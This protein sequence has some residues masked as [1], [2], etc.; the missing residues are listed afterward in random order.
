MQLT[1]VINIKRK[2]ILNRLWRLTVNKVKILS[3]YF[4]GVKGYLITVNAVSLQKK[5]SKQRTHVINIYSTSTHCM[6]SVKCMST[7]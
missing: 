4:H 5:T 2:Q 1:D 7:I 6:C 3:Q